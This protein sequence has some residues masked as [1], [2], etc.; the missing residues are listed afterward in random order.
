MA[1]LQLVIPEREVG[2]QCDIAWDS[3]MIDLKDAAAQ[4]GNLSAQQRVQWSLENLPGKHVLFSSFGVQSAV[5]LHMAS[6]VQSNIP[7]VLID[8]G[9]LFPETYRFVDELVSRL[10]LNLVIYRPL[11]S[12]SHQEVRFGRLWEAGIEGINQYNQMNKVEPM[13]RAFSELGVQTWFSGVRRSQSGSRSHLPVTVHQHGS[14]KVHPIVD[15]TNREVHRYLKKHHLPY[16]PLWDQGYVS[17]GDIHTS[18]PLQPGMLEEETRFF[19]LKRECGL[20]E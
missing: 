17:V 18:R 1:E 15:W 3:P 2:A 9:Y 13:K 20:H 8:T 5:M 6:E 14:Y 4:L 16:H 10:S 19:G 7:V 12:S 11:L